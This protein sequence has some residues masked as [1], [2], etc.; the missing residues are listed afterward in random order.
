[1][2][3]SI[4]IAGFSTSYKRP[5]AVRETKY[6]QGLVSV[7]SAQVAC[8]ITGTKTSAGSMTADQDVARIYDKDDADAKLGTGSEAACQ[9]YAALD[10]PGVVLW[11]APV[12][13]AGGAASATLV[14]TITGSWTTTGTAVLWLFGFAVSFQVV[15]GESVTQAAVRLVNAINAVPRFPFTAA[16]AAGVVTITVRSKG[17]RGNEHIGRKDLSAAPSGFAMALAGGTPLTGGMVPFSGGSGADSVVNVLGVLVSG[18]YDYQAWAQNDATNAALWKAQ[19]NSEAGPTAMH[20]EHGIMALTR[21]QAT[22]ISFSQTTLNAYRCSLVTMENCEVPSSVVAAQM[23]AVRSTIVGANP[24]Y[25]FDDYVLPSIPPQSQKADIYSDPELDAM[26]N[27][28]VTPLLTRPDGTVVIVRAVQSHSLNG[29]APDYRTLDWGDADVPDRMSK[30]YGVRWDTFSA[31]N[32]YVG[33]DPADGEEQPGEGVATPTLWRAEII[34]I[35]KDAEKANWLQSVDA[36]PPVVEYDDDASRLMTA[37][38][39]VVRK[40]NHQVGISVRQVAA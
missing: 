35:N 14:A 40:Q 7:G 28:G 34:D 21:A 20:L 16:N 19:L 39:I 17:V 37:A 3:S 33:A 23:A 10:I 26:L 4:V 27:S 8:L 25:R 2:T 18:V 24:N 1:M 6:G 5:G 11:A 22:A 15:A 30:E 32:M 12:A 9:A 36:N 29:S 13:E 38:P 31:G